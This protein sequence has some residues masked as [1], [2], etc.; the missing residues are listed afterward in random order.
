MC[1]VN[2]PAGGFDSHAL[3]PF[4]HI[5][6]DIGIHGTLPPFFVR[7]FGIWRTPHFTLSRQTK[8]ERKRVYDQ[9][10]YISSGCRCNRD[11]PGLPIDPET[12]PRPRKHSFKGGR[13][14]HP[15]QPI[16]YRV[17]TTSLSWP[18]S[19]NCPS[20]ERHPGT[21]LGQRLIPMADYPTSKP[22]GRLSKIKASGS[23]RSSSMPSWLRVRPSTKSAA[24]WP[25]R[26]EARHNRDAGRPQWALRQ[27]ALAQH[28]ACRSLV[29]TLKP[30]RISESAYLDENRSSSAGLLPIRERMA[31]SQRRN[32]V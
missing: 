16:F 14:V 17:K 13:F 23:A 4:L 26:L 1:R 5:P 19:Q 28:F 32:T 2:S 24:R 22:Q 31:V 11:Q 15:A 27:S 18:A 8:K 10:F 29:Y 20:P 3:P 9:T 25:N 7:F 12:K 30:Y 21:G 6:L